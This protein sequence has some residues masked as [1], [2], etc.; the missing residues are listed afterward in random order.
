MFCHCYLVR[1]LLLEFGEDQ[2]KLGVSDCVRQNDSLNIAPTKKIDCRGID[3]LYHAP[4][5]D[6]FVCCSEFI[7][8]RTEQ[9]PT[10]SHCS[11]LTSPLH[12][13]KIGGEV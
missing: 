12:Q 11:Q 3:F 6:I 4:Y 7:V 10:E 1:T 2:P 8:G 13:Q 5:L 9:P